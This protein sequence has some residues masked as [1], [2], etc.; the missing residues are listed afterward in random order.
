M[1]DYV[2]DMMTDMYEV[3]QIEI[4]IMLL[5]EGFTNR[6]EKIEDRVYVAEAK[7]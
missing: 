1:K 4:K 5:I 6:F 3:R 2:H 7:V